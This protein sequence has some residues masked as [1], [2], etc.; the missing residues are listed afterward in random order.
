MN[1]K[2]LEIVLRGQKITVFFGKIKMAGIGGPPSM[3]V[4][5]AVVFTNIG[6]VHCRILGAHFFF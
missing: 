6:R 2:G 3:R 5:V 4:L 1:Y